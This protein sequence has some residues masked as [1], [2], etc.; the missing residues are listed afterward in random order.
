[1]GWIIV[2][3][4]I[5]V[6]VNWD[7]IVNSLDGGTPTTTTQ[8]ASSSTQGASTPST[9]GKNFSLDILAGKL[10]GFDVFKVRVK[11]PLTFRNYTNNIVAFR[12]EMYDQ[13][14]GSP[15]PI[16]CQLE[17]FSAS[18]VPVFQYVTDPI[19]IDSKGIEWQS[20]SQL[21]AI[22]I[23]ALVFPFKGTR[24]IAISVTVLQATSSQLSTIK[25]VE[26]IIKY[27]VDYVGYA[28]AKDQRKKFNENVVKTA[29]EIAFIDGNIAKEERAYLKD[30][31]INKLAID[32]D[33]RRHLSSTLNESL[34]IIEGLTEAPDKRL[35]RYLKNMLD[36]SDKKDLTMAMEIF[37]NLVSVDDQLDPEEDKVITLIADKLGLSV[38][39][40]REL[41][42]KFVPVK[43]TKGKAAESH[44]DLSAHKTN[45]AKR[46]YLR[47]EYKKWN[48]LTT[49]SDT[50][51]RQQAQ[52]MLKLIAIERAKLSA[53]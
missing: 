41:K 50:S 38:D 27:Q 35:N 4:V 7:S 15:T 36:A 30:K 28:E 25:K 3:I 26:K 45:D 23:D 8:R 44:L 34:S 51:V 48:A 52:S 39:K 20:Y 9:R 13:T 49:S 17:Q 2:I 21:I 29:V 31:V 33:E 16:V 6:W 46:K 42:S 14:S 47:E 11:G 32:D 40:L 18:D 22:P 5:I 37:L 12:V 1:M 10:E 43:L 53:A 19:V 24:D